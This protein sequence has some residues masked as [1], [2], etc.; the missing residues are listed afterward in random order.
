[1]YAQTQQL[2]ANLVS[3]KIVPGVSYAILNQSEV[4][5]DVFGWREVMPERQKLIPGLQYDLA[6]LTKVIG[7]ATVIF[8]LVEQGKLSLADP[9]QKYLPEFTDPRV[10]V[11]HLL[12]HTSG[13]AGYIPHRDDLSAA[14]LKAALLKFPVTETFE[15][16]MIYTDVGFLYLGWIIEQIYQLPVQQVISQQVLRPLQLRGATFTPAPANC[17]PTNRRDGTLLQGTV[18]DPKAHTLG[19][20]CGSAGLFA[21]LA[22]LVQFSQWYL[23]QRPDLPAVISPEFIHELFADRT[24]HQLQRSLS[25]ALKFA[26]Q[27]QHSLIFHSGYTG[28]F[29]LLDEQL[30]Q[31]LVVLTNRVHPV[32]KNDLFLE[33]RHEIVQQFMR[34]LPIYLV[35]GK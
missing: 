6:S 12:T 24:R 2:L 27:D 32:E 14:A 22:D 25:W 10:Q 11:W 19:E 34:E 23:G 31:G 3:D 7:T 28:T 9:V 20:H 18:H 21:T 30:Q 5:T 35:G 1:M 15:H 4:L 29:M 13:I 17:V 26:P 16:E 33:K 8:Q